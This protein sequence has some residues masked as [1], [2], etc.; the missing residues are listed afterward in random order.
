MQELLDNTCWK[1][2]TSKSKSKYYFLNIETGV[3]QWNFP[4]SL[5]PLPKD[6]NRYKSKTAESYYYVNMSTGEKTWNKP[7][8][9]S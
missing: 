1:Q 8:G 2:I 7:S 4:N 9:K 5:Y 6:W 3:S